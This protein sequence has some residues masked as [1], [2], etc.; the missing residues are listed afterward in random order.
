M[1]FI[2]DF[3]GNIFGYILWFFFDAVSN[4]AV[5]ITLFAIFIN[6]LMLPIAVKR[7]KNMALNARINAKDQ[8]LKKKYEKNP[9]KYNEERALLYEKEG[10]D[11]MAGC[12]STMVLPLLLWSGIFGAITK[13]LQNTLH[14]AQEK[15]SQAISILPNIPELEGKINSG[16]EQLQLVRHFETVKDRL[17]M[18][19]AAEFADV[20][21]YSY[22]FNFFGINLLNRPNASS[23][24]E[25]LWIVPLLCLISSLFAI[26]VNQ[27]MM[28]TQTQIQ[29]CAKFLPYG[30]TLFTTYLA[31]TVPGAVGLYWFINALIGVLQS[32]WLNKYYNTYTINAKNEAARLALLEIQEESVSC[33]KDP[34]DVK[35]TYGQSKVFS[36]LK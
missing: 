32:L 25:M 18:F 27:K 14:I 30:T 17:T 28:G 22:G 24:S 2:F 15:V 33:I 19:N 26:Y 23:F 36:K 1:G 4:Y 9:K 13:P 8:E 34:K 21:E 31:Y 5:A 16:Y 7:Q 35:L 10:V 11:P 3:L 6:L 29:G 20:E 12:F